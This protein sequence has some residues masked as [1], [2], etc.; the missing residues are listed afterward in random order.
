M[1]ARRISIDGRNVPY[2]DQA[3][4]PSIATLTGLPATAMPIG[5]SDDGLP[6]GMQIIGP[7]L[8]DGTTIAFATLVD[9]ELGG[10][11]VPPMAKN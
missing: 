7:H 9:R 8:E 1:N 5:R 10:F 4:W 6:I 2:S 3:M 11:V